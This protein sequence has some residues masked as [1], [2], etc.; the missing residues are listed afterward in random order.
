MLLLIVPV[1]LIITDQMEKYSHLLN[2]NNRP[3]VSHSL[4]LPLKLP[5]SYFVTKNFLITIF[6]IPYFSAIYI[7]HPSPRSVFIVLPRERPCTP[8]GNATVYPSGALV[9]SCGNATVLP[10]EHPF[11]KTSPNLPISGYPPRPRVGG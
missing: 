8:S 2:F 4:F 6:L 11:P 10:R 9:F 3:I 5:V 7:F 1:H